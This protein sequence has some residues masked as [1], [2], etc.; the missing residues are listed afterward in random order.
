MIIYSD[1]IKF[2]RVNEEDIF[3]A[4]KGVYGQCRGGYAITAMIA[5]MLSNLTA[6]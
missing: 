6:F 3:S 4:L 1:N 2:Y 5:G